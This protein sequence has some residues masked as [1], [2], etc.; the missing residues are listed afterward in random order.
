MNSK[1]EL[2]Q[3]YTPADVAG[4]LVAMVDA[5]PTHI[6]DLG[7]GHGSLSKAAIARWGRPIKLTTMDIDPEAYEQENPWSDSHSHYRC[8]LLDREAFDRITGGLRFDLAL[9]NPPYGRCEIPAVLTDHDKRKSSA[10]TIMR[11]RSTIFML[12]ALSVVQHGGT[13]A[14]ILPETIAVGAGYNANRRA[15]SAVSKVDRVV[16]LRTNTFSG[17]EARTVMIIFRRV[18]PK[19]GDPAPWSETQPKNED[20]TVSLASSSTISELGVEVV[21]GRLNTKEARDVGAFHLGAFKS[22]KNGVIDLS[23]EGN[24]H[25]DRSACV[26]DILVARI[27]RNI[28]EKVVLVGAGSNTISDCVFRLRCAPSVSKRVW[29]GLRSAPGKRQLEASL[30]GVTTRLLPLRNLLN[31]RV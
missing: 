25:D 9:L 8:D 6:L 20:E 24:F 30:S 12:R 26:G 29:N 22:A 13:V 7:C 4:L 2:G 19:D 3:F 16:P 27:G 10:P 15:I 31:L 28:S 18:A 1:K 5:E 23:V 17:T 21:R 11:C 14:A